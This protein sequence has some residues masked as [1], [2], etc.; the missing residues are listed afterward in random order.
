MTYNLHEVTNQ[1]ITIIIVIIMIIVAVV[2]VNI[3]I[4]EVVRKYLPSHK[5]LQ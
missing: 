4:D 3:I 2:V 5:Q 1:S